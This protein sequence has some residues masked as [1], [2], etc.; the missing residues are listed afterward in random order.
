M[1]YVIIGR[2]PGDDEDTVYVCRADNRNDAEH[3]FELDMHS[4]LTLDE[5][6]TIKATYGASL[7]MNWILASETPITTL[8]TNP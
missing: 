6:D 1:H 5:I 4:E 7:I 8:S 3:M 2:I